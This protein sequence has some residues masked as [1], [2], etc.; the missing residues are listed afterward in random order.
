MIVFAH[1]LL[2]YIE[3]VCMI[4]SGVSIFNLPLNFK[5]ISM[6]GFLHAFVT[7]FIRR[8]YTIYHIPFG[9]HSLIIWFILFLLIKYVL[10]FSWLQSIVTT[11]IGIGLLLFG[12]GVFLLPMMNFLGID[13]TTVTQE[14]HSFIL[15]SLLAYI[16]MM[17]V[18]IFCYI[19]KSPVINIKELEDT[20][21]W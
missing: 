8:L 9:T 19:V 3:G 20:E 12:E 11:L 15:I 14:V 10:Q 13:L 7:Y 18:I 1:F 5:K 4:G 2:Y 16:P 21:K 6:S 17:L